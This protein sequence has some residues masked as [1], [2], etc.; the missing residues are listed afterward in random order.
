MSCPSQLNAFP[1]FILRLIFSRMSFVVVAAVA[2]IVVVIVI[3]IV[4]IG[5]N[6]IHE[7]GQ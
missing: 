7:H 1:I 3:I 6:S 5:L 2:V 4:I